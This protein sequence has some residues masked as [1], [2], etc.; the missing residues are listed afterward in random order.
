LPTLLRAGDLLVANNSRVLAARLHARK[1]TT[2]GTVELLLLRPD[3]EGRWSA[4]ARP[5]RRLKPGTSLLLGDRRTE[6]TARLEIETVESDGLVTVRLP[7]IVEGHLADWGEVPLPPYVHQQIADPERYQTVYATVEGSVAAPTAGLHFTPELRR[8]LRE[9]GVGWAEVTLHVGL[10]TFRPVTAERLAEHQIHQEWCEV[11]DET[12]QVIA[13]TRQAGGR[14]IAVGT[15]SA[16]TLE[17]LSR[18]W[19]D[20][21][22]RGFAGMT[23]IYILPGHRWRLVDGLL[24][25]FHLPRTTLLAMVSALASWERIRVAYQAAIVERYRFYSF[26]DAM[27]IL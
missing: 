1:E 20:A 18:T 24:T 4:L 6:E 10:D 17:T 23:G 14:V 27:L 9:R 16:R 11:S 12:A 15:T 26:G 13:A 2:G 5:S 19:S 3:G 25:N 7:S 22:P 8:E 21:E